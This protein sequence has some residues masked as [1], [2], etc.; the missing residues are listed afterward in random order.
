[1]VRVIIAVLAL[2]FWAVAEP[3]ELERGDRA[4]LEYGRQYDRYEAFLNA[5]EYT[6]YSCIGLKPPIVEYKSLRRGLLGT[7][8][9]GNVIY[10]RRGLRGYQRKEVLMHETVHYIQAQVGGLVVPGPAKQICYAEE[11]TFKAVDRWL[12]DMNK[13]YMVVGPKWW[14]PYEHCY[15]WFNPKYRDAGL[16]QQIK[17]DFF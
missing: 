15:Q 1:M 13:E 17:W 10:V 16:I 11:E 7:Y 2:S 5:C 14:T 4:E 6:T 3:K 12:V 9:G 8:R